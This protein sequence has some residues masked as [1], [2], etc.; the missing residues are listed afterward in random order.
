[1]PLAGTLAIFPKKKNDMT[2]LGGR[3]LVALNL[4]QSIMGSVEDE[5]RRVVAKETLAHVHD[6]LHRRSL[7]GLIDNRPKHKISA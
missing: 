4:A 6:G 2:Y 5:L 3:I 1:M 7:S